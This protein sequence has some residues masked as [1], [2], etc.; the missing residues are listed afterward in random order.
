MFRVEKLGSKGNGLVADQVI[1]EGTRIG[2]YKGALVPD[3]GESDV[4]TLIGYITAYGHGRTLID[5]ED[6]EYGCLLY[7]G[8]FSHEPNCH[9]YEVHG[10]PWLV[11]S[12]RIQVG[13][14]LTY[15][16]G[17][18]YV[19]DVPYL[20]RK[21]ACLCGTKSC[22]GFIVDFIATREF[23]PLRRNAVLLIRNLIQFGPQNNF[24]KR[25]MIHT[26]RDDLEWLPKSLHSKVRRW[27][28]LTCPRFE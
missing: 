15:S 11:T 13:E 20:R 18:S 10:M 9:F 21:W 5:P 19:P 1:P 6:H 26:S 25:L 4:S 24:Q 14:E 22:T 28:S 3:C 2:P 16:Y 12:R 23:E 17:I 8:N 7:Y 27:A